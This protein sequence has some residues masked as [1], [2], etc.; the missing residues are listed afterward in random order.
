MSPPPLPPDEPR[1]L[2][3]LQALRIL[4]TEPEERF[5]RIART[6]V[7]LF[8]VPVALV[9]LVDANRQWF[10]CRIGFGPPETPREVSFCAHAVAA[11]A[12]LVVPDARADAR[13]ADNPLVT[14]PSR[15]RFYA[16]QPLHAADGSP[17]GTLCVIDTEPHAFGEG[18]RAAL[19]DLAGWAELE[20]GALTTAQTRAAIEQQERFFELS[21]DPLCVLGYDGRLQRASRSCG[22]ALGLPPEA[23]R[24]VS[25]AGRVHPEDRARVERALAE[26]EGGGR[27]VRFEVRAPR[28]DGELRWLEWLAVP[29]A[30]ERILYAV[31]R[32]VTDQKALEAERGR[33]ERMKSEF[34]STVS[35]ELRTPLTSIRGSLGLIEGGVMGELPAPALDMVRIARSNTERLIRLINDMLDLEKIE[36]GKLELHLQR[37]DAAELLHATLAALE[38]V[39]GAARVRLVAE[40]APGLLVRG[41]RDRLQQVLTNL[42]S[43][44]VKFSPEGGE[45]RARA[46]PEEGA[47]GAQAMRFEVV[48]QGPGIPE[49]A[50]GRLFG[51]FQQLDS[52]DTRSKGGTGLGLAIS[53]AIVAQHGSRIE[54]ESPPGRGATFRFRLPREA[55][56]AEAA[57]R[58]AEA[59]PRVLLVEDDEALSEVLTGLL[60]HEGYRVERAKSLAEARGL[61]ARGLPD[62]VLL[63][64]LLPDGNGLDWMHELRG[65]EATRALPVVVLSGRAGGAGGAGGAGAPLWMDWMEKPF[66]EG[67]LLA[68]LQRARREKGEGRVLVVEDDAAARTLLCTQLTRMGLECLQASD[69][70]RALQLARDHAPDLIIL[71]VGLP[72][73]NGFEVVDLLRR[74]PGRATPLVVFTA[75]DLTEEQRRQLT[76][77][78]TRHLTK[79]RASEEE[80]LESVR[81]LLR[82][83]RPP[84]PPARGGS[85]G[86]GGG[87]AP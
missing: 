67:H 73:L 49:A 23:L 84:A 41:D 53:Q 2:A 69:G 47:H 44:A 12:M 78:L 65:A 39:A 82:G 77:G 56:P 71:D 8:R 38:G 25:L 4:D 20:L 66:E 45:V 13:F 63:D 1:R 19:A 59:G 28:A 50:R 15:V 6:A 57:S 35:H 85:G 17:V 64:I 26:A 68:A 87:G 21:A 51:K 42:V 83:L 79:A 36:A 10:K 43:N 80:L 11:D 60:A 3:A 14:G 55:S 30:H 75:H 76:L 46:L 32:D 7:R 22:A 29:S 81:A 48:D 61:L 33:V 34:V 72:R 31:G 58:L 86:G 74:G 18:E 27:L 9:S 5:E 24:G 16:G 52:S 40:A 62:V 37:L 70:E 54:V